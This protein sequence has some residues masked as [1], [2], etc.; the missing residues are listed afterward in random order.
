MKRHILRHVIF[1]FRNCYN[2]FL[3]T[4]KKK[5]TK[6]QNE[7]YIS[8]SSIEKFISINTKIERIFLSE[9]PTTMRIEL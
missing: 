3:T 1:G 2:F 5:F 6:L 8:S 7:Y 4:A 9:D